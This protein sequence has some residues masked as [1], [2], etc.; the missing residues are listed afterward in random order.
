[1]LK[2]AMYMHIVRKHMDILG[3][4]DIQWIWIWSDIHARG[5]FHGWSA[6]RLKN[7][8][9]DLVL[10]YLSKPAPLPSLNKNHV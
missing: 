7:L 8:G 10:V 1:M 9:M 4:P 3:Y 5:Y 6:A 2:Y